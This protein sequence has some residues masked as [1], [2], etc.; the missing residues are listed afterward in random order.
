M[1]DLFD[2]VTVGKW[3]LSIRV[4]MAPMTRNRA[5]PGGVPQDMTATYYQQR[6]TAGLISP[7][8]CSLVPSG[9]AT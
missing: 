1:P 2:T 3:N 9:R 4:A 6:A 5:G 7:R 8:V